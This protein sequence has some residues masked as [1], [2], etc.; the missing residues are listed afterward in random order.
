MNPLF[1]VNTSK[2]FESACT[3]LQTA[4]IKQG[5][6]VMAVHDL[7]E[8]L[9]SKG[10]TFAESCRVFEVCSPQQAA[11]VL[12]HDM[13]LNMALPCRISVYTDAGQTL[14]GMIRPSEMLHALSS[15]PE[16]IDLARQVDTSTSA[17]IKDAAVESELAS[18][19]AHQTI[20]P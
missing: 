10:I 6:G 9:R 2:S 3:D 11:K 12:A 16:L 18:H 1:V 5:F 20:V 13:S 17:M 14:I 15:D 7:G 8:T 4:V 19:S